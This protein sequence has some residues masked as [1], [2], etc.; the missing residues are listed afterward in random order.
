[1]LLSVITESRQ[2]IVNEMTS[3][4]VAILP[5]V[6]KSRVETEKRHTTKRYQSL[7]RLKSASLIFHASLFNVM[8]CVTFPNYQMQQ[9]V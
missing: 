4:K 8:H 2:S 3:Q 1:M 5:T 6:I 7:S 9:I